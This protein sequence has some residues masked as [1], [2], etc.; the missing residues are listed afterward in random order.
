MEGNNFISKEEHLNSS[1]DQTNEVK[2]EI[3]SESF[4]NVI[5]F[6]NTNKKIVVSE[7]DF[8]ADEGLTVRDPKEY[9]GKGWF[10]EHGGPRSIADTSPWFFTFRF[11][12]EDGNICDV[13]TSIDEISEKIPSLKEK[14]DYLL[15]V[16]KE[17]LQDSGIKFSYKAEGG[18][19]APYQV[20]SYVYERKQK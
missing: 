20:D 13:D 11:F 8:R 17:R 5:D 10:I 4:E 2:L 6:I 16:F 3:H 14:K 15:D 9:K 19:M 7:A 18:M 1:K 12:D